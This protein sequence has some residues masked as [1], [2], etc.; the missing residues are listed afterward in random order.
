M[1]KQA[2]LATA[3]LGPSRTRGTAMKIWVTA[4][5]LSMLLGCIRVE[6]TTDIPGRHTSYIFEFQW[7]MFWLITH[8]I[9]LLVV[10]AAVLYGCN[11]L[12]SILAELRKLNRHDKP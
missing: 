3:F 8:A 6:D 4:C 7:D 1:G 5:G 10:V 9:F 2:S 11:R 12:N